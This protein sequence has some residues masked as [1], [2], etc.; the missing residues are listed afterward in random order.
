M[1]DSTS[2]DHKYRGAR[3]DYVYWFEPHPGAM[4]TFQYTASSKLVDTVQDLIKLLDE[5][6]VANISAAKDAEQS[7]SWAI[8]PDKKQEVPWYAHSIPF[9]LSST[10]VHH[11]IIWPIPGI[12][13][14][15]R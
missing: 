9:S 14:L 4:A 1:G 5:E 3:G 7:K 10:F 2:L 11:H 8:D 12:P 15:W 6:G 13:K